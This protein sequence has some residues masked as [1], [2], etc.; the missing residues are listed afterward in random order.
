MLAALVAM[1]L[2]ALLCWLLR[3]HV[4]LT[5]IELSTPRPNQSLEPTAGRRDVQI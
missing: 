5:R 3:H 1:L 2:T 4:P